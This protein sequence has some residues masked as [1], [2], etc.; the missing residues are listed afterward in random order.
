MLQ[1]GDAMHGPYRASF[2]LAKYSNGRSPED[3]EPDE[4][5][6]VSQWFEQ[7][8]MPIDDEQRIADLDAANPLPEVS[9]G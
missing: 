7:D 3:G 4:V 8:G 2:H 9:S 5:V 1:T 6:F